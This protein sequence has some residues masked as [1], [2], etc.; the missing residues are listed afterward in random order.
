MIL[1]YSVQLALADY[2]C[3]LREQVYGL[4]RWVTRWRGLPRVVGVRETPWLMGHIRATDEHG[5]EIPRVTRIDRA[6]GELERYVADDDGHIMLA[7]D[8]EHGLRETVRMPC[9]VT[10]A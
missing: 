10:W 9:R 4:R 3:R 6:I 2:C 7:P 5:R 8:R 1:S